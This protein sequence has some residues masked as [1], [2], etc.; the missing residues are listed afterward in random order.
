MAR[1]QLTLPQDFVE[2][3]EALQKAGTEDVASRSSHNKAAFKKVLDH[4]GE[5]KDIRKGIEQLK[6][7]VDKHFGDGDDAA[8]S[9]KLVEAILGK[10][11]DEY[12]NLHK[13]IMLLLVGPYKDM[14]LEC[15]FMVS[16][17][18]NSF[19]GKA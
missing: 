12:I 15:Q 1:W 18:R 4:H 13:R 5:S 19:K 10:L 16:D 14:G 11:E 2:N 8:L 3:V 17:I 6:K 7:R 9:H